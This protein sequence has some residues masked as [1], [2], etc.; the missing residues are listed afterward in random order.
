MTITGADGD[1]LTLI[2]HR[3]SGPQAT[4]PAVVHFHGGGGV[5]LK[6]TD[7][8]YERW[9]DELAASGLL[10]VGVEF[11]NAAGA[12]GTHPFPAGLNDC[13][14]AVRW[15][16]AHKEELGVGE[17]VMSGESGGG[18]LA[19][20]VA[21]R[22]NREGWV[23]EI[24]GVYA[25]A[26]M[27][28]GAWG[29]PDDLP[30]QRENDGYF[31]S[32]ALLDIMG[33]TYD[34]GGRHGN[35]ATCWPFLAADADLEGLP[36]HVVSVN[37]LDPLRDEGLAY[38]RRLVSNGVSAIGRTVNGTVHGGDVFFRAALPDVYASTIR[39]ISGFA[40]QL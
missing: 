8:C 18:N 27:I 30:S 1:E 26:P 10:V 37:E 2:I 17:V 40:K 39:D 14:A 9:R 22:A 13:A 12:L 3:P 4:L 16:A 33:A 28:S 15:V 21:I 34:P 38:Q 24:S 5:I 20:A 29:M 23:D 11:R 25:M 6:A 19:L 7:S 32:C 36:P 31:I 35:E